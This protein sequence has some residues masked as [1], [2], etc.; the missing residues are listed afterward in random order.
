MCREANR[1]T[2]HVG[3]IPYFPWAIELRHSLNLSLFF[4]GGKVNQQA[5]TVNHVGFFFQCHFFIQFILQCRANKS[6]RRSG[7]KKLF[8]PG[9]ESSRQA[10]SRKSVLS[11]QQAG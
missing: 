2:H 1:D 5:G 7:G 11:D 4:G 10:V 6:R 8:A 9:P 3:V